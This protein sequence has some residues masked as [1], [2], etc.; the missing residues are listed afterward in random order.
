MHLVVQR[1]TPLSDDD[2]ARIG[3]LFQALDG[4]RIPG[5]GLRYT[6]AAGAPVHRAAIHELGR[7]QGLDTA[8]IDDFRPL[9]DFKLLVFDMDSTLINIECIDELAD[10][11]GRKREVARLTEQAMQSGA[12]DYDTSLRMRTRLLAGLPVATFE[13][14][15][16]ERV[17]ITPGAPALIAAARQAGLRTAIV[18]G[19]FD[20]FTGRVRAELGLDVD[21]SN[22]LEVADGR[23]T[24]ELLGTL[25][26]ADAK[27]GH[28][29]R[30]CRELGVPTSDAIVVGDG[31]NDLKMMAL[32]GLS[33]GYRPKPVV[34]ATVNAVI[35]RLG[36]DSLLNVLGAADREGCPL[37]S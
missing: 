16:A 7:Q 4:R 24:G 9:S 27:A 3:A 22:H 10:L 21:L 35:D 17:R 6:L 33:V 25:I 26:N 5:G 8:V 29:A 37:P 18:S 20:Y 23:L 36:L 34:R 32:A 14:L 15:Y 2:A 13:S 31:A 19:G 11:V 30:M 12:V 28:V 1:N